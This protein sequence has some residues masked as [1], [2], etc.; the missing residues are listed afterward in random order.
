MGLMP[1]VILWN[2]E[3]LK[4]LN[5]GIWTLVFGFL[6]SLC[7]PGGRWPR[8]KQSENENETD[9]RK[10][11]APKRWWEVRW[12]SVQLKIKLG[13]ER[14]LNFNTKFFQHA[15]RRRS[16]RRQRRQVK[17]ATSDSKKIKRCM[18]AGYVCW[19]KQKL[20]KRKKWKTTSRHLKS[21]RG[22]G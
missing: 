6:F 9:R 11:G 4:Y 14:N 13:S 21:V 12:S 5:E 18:C 3:T 17:P 8:R 20:N 7:T 16:R 2:Y 22:D 10:D 15:A 1:E 19:A